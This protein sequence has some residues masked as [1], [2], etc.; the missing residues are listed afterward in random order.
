LLALPP[1][2]SSRVMAD[3]ERRDST[4]MFPSAARWRGAKRPRHL[5]FRWFL[6]KVFRHDTSKVGGVWGRGRKLFKDGELGTKMQVAGGVGFFLGDA[7]RTSQAGLTASPGERRALAR[8]RGAVSAP[9]APSAAG[10]W[11]TLGAGGAPGKGNDRAVPS[12]RPDSSPSAVFRD[13]P[14]RNS[15]SLARYLFPCLSVFLVPASAELQHHG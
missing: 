6:G 15:A 9:A 3:A 12:R 7:L 13:D 2:R 14:Q 8:G 10:I 5:V 11:R 4:R 1:V